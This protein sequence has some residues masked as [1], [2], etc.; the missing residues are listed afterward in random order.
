MT[1]SE[2]IVVT[3]ASGQVGRL[4]LKELRA[5]AP[6]ARLIGFVRDPAKAQDLADRGVELRVGSYDDPASIAAALK[7]ADKL[8]LISASEV[9]KRLPQHRNVIEAAKAEGVKLFAYTSILRAETSPLALAEEHKA[10]EALIRESGLPFVFLRNG[11]YTENY[12]ANIGAAL[13]HEAVLGSA[14]DGRLSLASRADYA[15]AAAAVLASGEDQAGR[16]YELAGD[17]GYT[18]QA[19][20]SEIA[21]QSGK[22]VTYRDLPQAEYKAVLV[23]VGLPEAYADLLADS[24]AKAAKGALYED[25]GAMRGLIGRPTTPLA[26]SVA[27]ALAA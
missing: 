16:I 21:K 5:R 15:A 14:G 23:S 4:V 11:W 3:G 27:A 2:T 1:V 24:D 17:E 12:T 6:Q 10:T 20:A 9:G 18:L 25:G 22:P 26:E 8:L 19:Y 13:Q 7:G